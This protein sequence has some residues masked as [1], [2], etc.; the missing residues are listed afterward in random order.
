MKRSWWVIAAAVPLVVIGSVAIWQLSGDDR[1]IGAVTASSEPVG[2]SWRGPWSS[3]AS[4]QPGQV[5]AFDGSSYVAQAE[6]KGTKPTNQDAWA[7]M[8]S[9]GAQGQTGAAGPPGPS[10]AYS[11]STSW[12][13]LV[14]ATYTTI[15]SLSLPAGNYALIARLELDN[16]ADDGSGVQMTCRLRSGTT[17]LDTTNF[18]LTARPPGYPSNVLRSDGHVPLAGTL[19][20][21]NAGDVQVQCSKGFQETEARVPRLMAV[22]VDQV[23]VSP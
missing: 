1:R 12:Q 2:L 6:S 20:L 13:S 10:G 15:G 5:V 9:R 18:I 14:T 16:K 3:E 7:L 23:T 8:A 11:T 19:T 21:A 22:K 4:Y 17:N